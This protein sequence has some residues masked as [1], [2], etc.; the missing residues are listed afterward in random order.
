MLMKKSKLLEE[1]HLNG[2]SN[3]LHHNFNWSIDSQFTV[4]EAN[5]WDEIDKKLNEL[6]MKGIATA[7]FTYGKEL[8]KK[9][10][11]TST[12]DKREAREFKAYAFN[13]YIPQL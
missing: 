8:Y 12:A 3:N 13:L 9:M 5:A 2:K 1:M 6:S 7:Q 11:N 10:K 4:D